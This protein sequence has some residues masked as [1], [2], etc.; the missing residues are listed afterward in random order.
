[1]RSLPVR[2]VV[3][4][5][6]AIPFARPDAASADPK[7]N[8]W[9]KIVPKLNNVTG[10]AP[11]GFVLDVCD[12][13]VEN[14][15]PIVLCQDTGHEAQ[16]FKLVKVEK[17]WYKIV[18][19][20]NKATDGA[21]KGFVLDVCDAKV[22]N[23]NPIVLCEDTGNLAQQFKFVEVEKGWHKIVPKLN[24]RTDEAPKGFVLDVCD[25]K[26]ENRNPIV[27]CEDTGHE[28]QLFKLV[29]VDK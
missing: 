19:K 17:N 14:R 18:P 1:M 26:V 7:E 25:A 23:R 3:F 28:A 21:P 11:N 16:L 22:E 24:K 8:V 9:Y 15:N 13:K 29:P 10:D 27:L 4:L 6:L 20:L 12:A 5:A 2:F